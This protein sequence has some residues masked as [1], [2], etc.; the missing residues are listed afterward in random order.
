MRPRII[1][2]SCGITTPNGVKLVNT[3][4]SIYYLSVSELNGRS[5]RTV[6]SHWIQVL[7]PYMFTPCEASNGPTARCRR[8]WEAHILCLAMS[9]ERP[10]ATE[11]TTYAGDV[12]TTRPSTRTCR[13]RKDLIRAASGVYST[14]MRS[15]KQTNKRENCS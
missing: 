14:S 1:T 13:R 3:E 11:R 4:A 10:R 12:G 8:V 2:P 5:H 7:L 9:G 15:S 6:I